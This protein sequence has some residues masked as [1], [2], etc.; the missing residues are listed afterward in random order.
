MDGCPTCGGIWFEQKELKQVLGQGVAALDDLMGFEP[1][2]AQQSHPQSR[3][4]CPRCGIVLHRNQLAEAEDVAVNT[5][6]QCAG[7]YLEAAALARLDQDFHNPGGQTA[8]P[9]AMTAEE[10]Q[11]CQ[12]V[13]GIQEAKVGAMARLWNYRRY[14]GKWRDEMEVDGMGPLR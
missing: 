7:L 5:C 8:P 12:V 11:A 4:S 9:Q 1:A 14:S 2:Q 6:Y 10:Q 3:F 13:E